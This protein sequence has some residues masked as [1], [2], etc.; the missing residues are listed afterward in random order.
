VSI[1]TVQPNRGDV[2]FARLNPIEG[3]EQGGV[4][5][6]VVVSRDALNRFSPVVICVPVTDLANKK[7]LYPSHVKLNKGQ[8]GLTMDSVLLCEQVRSLSKTRL[9]KYI[10]RLDKPAL[11]SIDAA[12]KI[13]LDLS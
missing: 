10:G 13:A 2:F 5:P 4:R 6:V 12:L 1:A 3:S 11:T 9:E 7:K 8:G